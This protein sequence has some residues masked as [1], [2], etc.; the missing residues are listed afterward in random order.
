MT[1]GSARAFHATRHTA[2]VA[3]GTAPRRPFAVAD[4]RLADSPAGHTQPM[5]EREPPERDVSGEPRIG[6]VPYDETP[7][8]R[9]VWLARFSHHHA[10][11]GGCVGY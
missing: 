10:S 7:W 11:D 4:A 9:F 8:G 2:G 6:A 1:P 3:V 5:E